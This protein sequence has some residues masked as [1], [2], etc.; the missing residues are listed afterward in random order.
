MILYH[1]V[2]IITKYMIP[3]YE[4]QCFNKAGVQK[5]AGRDLPGVLPEEGDAGGMETPMNGC[6]IPNLDSER[7]RYLAERSGEP[8]IIPLFVRVPVPPFSPVELYRNLVMKPPGETGEP[9]RGFLLESMDGD[10][11][12]ATYSFIGTDPV[13]RVTCYHDCTEISGDPRYFGNI[14][15]PHGKDAIDTIKTL[16]NTFNVVSPHVPRFSGG[17]VGYF[18][19]DLVYSLLPGSARVRHKSE[20]AGPVAEFM[21]CLDCMVLDHYQ[22]DLWIV[23]N[24]ITGNGNDPDELF[25]EN[26]ATLL[27]RRGFV[28]KFLERHNHSGGVDQ[29]ERRVISGTTRGTSGGRDDTGIQ[30]PVKT[31]AANSDSVVLPEFSRPEGEKDTYTRSVRRVKELIHSGEVVQA[32]ISRKEAYIF[33]ENPLSLYQALRTINPSPYM[34]YLEF[35]D[36]SVIGAS[37]EMLVRVEGRTVTTVPIAGTRKR[38]T[39]EEEDRTLEKELLLDQK[40]RAEHVMLVDL[41]RNDIGSVCSYGSVRVPQFMQVGKYSH[42]QHIVS[43]VT[44]KIAQNFDRFDVFRA[45]FPAG[46]VSGAPK[47]RAIEIIDEHEPGPRGLYAGA[48]GYIGF[49]EGLEFAI[50]IR[51]A[52]VKDGKA[53]V[54]AGA[55]IVA[56][57]DPDREW[58]ET[59]QKLAAMKQAVQLAGGSA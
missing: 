3:A 9:S 13:L 11:K 26:L 14:Q 32:V 25:T 57:S 31:G 52:V 59:N 18:S 28:E 54:Q 33:R 53:L 43:T 4:N 55:G 51:T 35:P 30:A 36:Y 39:N 37:P 29:L 23:R 41:A 34:Y 27:E 46:T 22:S 16:I 17:L 10:R 1:N 45:C 42:V 50:A 6:S 7:F 38:G 58:I 12:I 56:D 47:I 2:F 44:G 5:P 15:V 19:Y 21:L 8:C 49:D 40:E 24:V 48:V 20:I